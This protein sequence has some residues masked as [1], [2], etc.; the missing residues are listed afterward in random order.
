[1]KRRE[2][3]T[4]LGGTMAAWPLA[5]PAQQGT[6]IKRIGVLMGLSEQDPQAQP[7]IAA[8]TTAL[9]ELGWQDGRNIQIDLRWAGGDVD[10][11]KRVANELV[12]LK[13][14]LIV[15]HSTAVVAA[16]QRETGTIPIVFV[17]VSDPVGSGFITSLSH[18]GGNITGFI[19]IESS[20]GG[21]WVELLKETAPRATRVALIHNPDTAPYA[22]YYLDPFVVA[23]RSSGIEPMS[24]PV[25]SES[26]IESVLTSIGQR[27][28]SGLIVMPDIFLATQ[29][30]FNLIVALAARYRLPTIYPYG[31]MVTA[32][33]LLSYGIDPVDLYRRA[34]TYIDQILKGAKAGELPVQLPTKFQLVINLKTAK[35]LNLTV[36]PTLLARADEVIE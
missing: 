23:S 15:A 31:Y 16:L 22:Q 13:S 34:P 2:F 21:K 3:I 19:N 32:G 30:N 9:R 5:V 29:R 10:Q 6:R 36:P 14:D 27:T 11:I 33:G 1:M 35:S 24:A 4:L 8:F 18:P 26:E 25:R 7:D 17:F 20:L 28:D 12:N